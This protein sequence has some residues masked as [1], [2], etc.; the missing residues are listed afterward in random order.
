M[1]NQDNLW[2][3]RDM[4]QHLQFQSL[5]AELS[6]NFV[7]ISVESVDDAIQE[8][9][10]RIA[11]NLDLDLVALGMLTVDG[12][13]FFSRYQY[14][15]GSIKPWLASSLMAEGPLL[16]QTLL[17]G[18]P[19]IMHDIDE[20]PPE[21]AIDREGFLHYGIRADLVFPILVGGHLR[22]GIGFASSRPRQWHD[23]VVQGL[24]LIT[25]VFAN[26]LER[27]RNLQALQD[28]EEQ[29]RLAAKA[30]D[31]ALWAWNIPMDTIWATDEAR[32]MYGIPPD[33]ALTWQRFLACLHPDD[34]E[35]VKDLAQK[36]VEDGSDFREE[37]R[38]VH[39]DG[40]EYWICATGKCQFD[41]IGRPVRMMGASLNITDTRQ[42]KKD[43]ELAND[44]LKTALEEIRNLKDQIQQ[45]NIYLRHEISECKGAQIVSGSEVMRDLWAQVQLVAPTPASVL[46]TGE[47]GTGKELLA[48]AI[49]EASPRKNRSMIR[50]NCAAIPAALIESELF[51]REKGA[52]TSAISKQVG[53]FELAN[54][55]TLFLDEVGELPLDAQAKLLR[56]LQEKEIER[57]GNPRPIKVD[58]RVIAATNRN[59]S[60]EVA[61]GRFRE[62]LYYRLNVF[63]LQVPALRDR[64]EDIPKLVEKFVNEFSRSMDK[65]II[66]VSKASIK[67][68]CDY[69]W[70]GNIR[71][72]RNVIERAVILAQDPI[73]KVVLA[74]DT[75]IPAKSEDS[76]LASMEDVERDHILQI[77]HTSGWRVRGQGGAA[78]ILKL[79]PCT[80][81]SRMKKLGIRRPS[82]KA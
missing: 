4:E 54:G 6:A 62:D 26:A 49:H 64:R 13:D 41:E 17:S 46:I 44:E 27:K 71:E 75:N 56:V 79:N 14:T 2:L 11:K 23:N 16:T 32:Q 47:T 60:M 34:G 3:L 24:G 42:T 9:L 10:E 25:D 77:L 45:E 18:Q 15:N 1:N 35:R 39:P 73:L 76:S 12:Q 81:E 69:D 74:N 70:P 53:R 40:T 31:V 52:Y 5:L 61:Q 8:S 55:S 68:L 38:I 80:L 78:E 30:A 19:F 82:S 67:T 22:G 29:M 43:L 37:Y 66:G 57:L 58:V 59:L 21:G 20:L 33:V 36:A 51:G 63:P 65:S 28:S 48:T 7:R 72:L 50:V